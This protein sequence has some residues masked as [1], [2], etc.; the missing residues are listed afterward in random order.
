MIRSGEEVNRSMEWL[1]KPLIKVGVICSFDFSLSPIPILPICF[2]EI[3][4]N[5]F[6]ST[7]GHTVWYA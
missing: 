5:T 1:S 3:A 7:Q 6:S 2:R 4:N